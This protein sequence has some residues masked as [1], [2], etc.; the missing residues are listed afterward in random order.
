MELVTLGDDSLDNIIFCFGKHSKEVCK[1][2]YGQFWS[3]R[4]S[5]R[6]SWKCHQMY[7][8]DKEK[9]ALELRENILENKGVPEVAGIET[10]ISNRINGLDLGLIDLVRFKDE[11][12]VGEKIKKTMVQNSSFFLTKVLMLIVTKSILFCS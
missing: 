9:K 1:K 8:T 7:T 11:V 2:I 10:W 12:H 6:L 4:E 5:A 3:T